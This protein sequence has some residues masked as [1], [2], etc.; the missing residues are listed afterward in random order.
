MFD[1]I[2][3][4]KETL[5]VRMIL[6]SIISNPSF[7]SVSISSNGYTRR[8]RKGLGTNCMTGVS[9]LVHPSLHCMVIMVGWYLRY[10]AVF[11]TRYDL[12]SHAGDIF[13][14]QGLSNQTVLIG[15]YRPA[16]P[17]PTRLRSTIN[18]S[19]LPTSEWL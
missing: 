6:T 14:Y 7:W 16:S 2:H 5:S 4:N 1:G 15:T 18:N 9:F 8:R 13:A 17:H 12:L 10:A 11:T 19:E 3:R